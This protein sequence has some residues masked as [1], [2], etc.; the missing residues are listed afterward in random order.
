MPEEDR[1]ACPC[2]HIVALAEKTA[3]EIK[4]VNKDISHMGDDL[5]NETKDLLE[6]YKGMNLQIKECL[7]TMQKTTIEFM[8]GVA[9]FERIEAEIANIKLEMATR[10]LASKEHSLEKIRSRQAEED[11][12]RGKINR[13][14]Y[15]AEATIV[16]T[17]FFLLK[18]HSVAVIDYISC[19]IK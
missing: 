10:Q 9:R 5:K 2:N 17:V 3:G 8:Q 11:N 15:I 7:E 12:Y 16:A 1:R 4:L 6:D 14:F 18:T 19:F 13:R